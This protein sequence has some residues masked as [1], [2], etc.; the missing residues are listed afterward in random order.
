MP[1]VPW[2]AA[3]RLVSLALI[4]RVFAG[5]LGYVASVEAGAEGREASGV[6]RRA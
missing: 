5:G 4:V 1:D 2:P 3:S 6:R